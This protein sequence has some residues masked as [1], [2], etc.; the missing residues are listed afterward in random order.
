[1]LPYIV[2]FISIDAQPNIMLTLVLVNNYMNTHNTYWLQQFGCCQFARW[3]KCPGTENQCYCHCVHSLNIHWGTHHNQ[4]DEFSYA[5]F[6]QQISKWILSVLTGYNDLN[7]ASY[8]FRI[9]KRNQSASDVAVVFLVY[10]AD[11]HSTFS[12]FPSSSM[13]PDV[14]RLIWWWLHETPAAFH[15]EYAWSNLFF[16]LKRKDPDVEEQIITKW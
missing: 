4:P 5:C 10:T 14:A 7:V 16:Y 2:F 13:V 15:I 6:T 1:M 3:D 9:R 8:L 11:G 12:L